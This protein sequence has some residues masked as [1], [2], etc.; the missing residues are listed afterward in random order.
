[1]ALDYS[2][3]LNV[4]LSD[5][6]DPPVPPVGHYGATIRSWK[7][8]TVDYKQGAGE[9]P[10]ATLYF[11]IS[12]EGE[13]VEQPLPEGVI[14]LLVDN[15]YDL[16]DPRALRGLGMAILGE[17]AKGL[18]LGDVLNSIVGHEVTLYMTTRMGKPGTAAEGRVFPNVNKVMVAQ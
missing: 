18:E 9:Q 3:Y 8:R 17:S 15:D 14:G 1:L 11:S 13:D 6:K 5:I 7:A 10:V 2:K 4:K 12:H 16:A